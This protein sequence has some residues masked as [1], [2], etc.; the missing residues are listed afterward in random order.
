MEALPQRQGLFRLMRGKPAELQEASGGVGPHRLQAMIDHAPDV[1]CL[2]DKNATF[3]YASPAIKSAFGYDPDAL[4][5]TNALTL[6]HPQDRPQMA[7]RLQTR[8][9]QPGTKGIGMCRFRHAD[10]SYRFIEASALNRLDDPKIGALVCWIR[11]VTEFRET[12]ATL[13]ERERRMIGVF[14]SVAEGII[15]TSDTGIIEDFNAAAERIFGYAR[16]DV[17]GKR[18]KLLIPEIWDDIHEDFVRDVKAMGEAGAATAPTRDIDGQHADGSEITLELSGGWFEHLGRSFFTVIVRD[19]SDKKRS[20]AALRVSEER[21]ALAAEAAS[22]GLWDWNVMENTVYFGP[23]WEKLLELDPGTLDDR[24]ETWFNRLHEADFA[25]FTTAFDMVLAGEVT[26]LEV[27]HRMLCGD[28][29]YRWFLTRGLGV[30]DAQGRVNRIVG[31]VSDIHGRKTA[32]D[33]A[34]HN[35]L[36]DVLTDLPNRQLLIDRIDQLYHRREIG[37]AKSSGLIV[38]DLDRFRVVNESLGH[39]T[40]DQILVTVARRLESAVRRGDTVARLGSDQFGVLIT[41][42]GD[43]AALQKRA[44]DFQSVLGTTITVGG[45]SA[46]LT[47]SVGL[48]PLDNETLAPEDLLRDALLASQEAKRLGGDQIVPFFLELRT[49]ALQTFQFEN[50]LRAAVR[51]GRVEAYYQPLVDID[52]GHPVGFEALARLHHPSRG[53]IPPSEFIPIAEETGLIAELA[54]QVLEQATEQLAA[55]KRNFPQLDPLAVTINLS[56]VQFDRQDVVGQLRRAIT[57]TGLR[58]N[59]LKIEITESL[60]MQNPERSS[61]ILRNIQALGVKIC[62]DD[63]GTGYSSLSYLRQFS[64]DTLKIDRSF[65]SRI[66]SDNRDAELVRTMIQLGQNVGMNVVAEGVETQSQLDVLYKFR[67]H[68]AQGYLFAKP[69]PANEATEWLKAQIESAEP[70]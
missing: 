22:D 44:E 39:R 8:V 40:G 61:Q 58:G 21:F 14:S 52:S 68:F 50:D 51:E 33:R 69:L 1:I 6:V 64:F 15:T 2:V 5:G 45:D 54:D 20:D 36:H 3:L 59:D 11:D 27:E 67:C 30:Q 17:I 65:V 47:A 13:R 7:Q 18:I 32:E 55:W 56:P 63:F 31:S 29:Q 26:T 37:P 12:L 41:E 24:I 23:R 4:T 38:I 66:V 60:L 46:D 62:V 48:R 43:P 49:S 25:Q 35:A 19:V 34:A 28:E 57:K 16:Q 53:I 70:A 42:T 9:E 10:G